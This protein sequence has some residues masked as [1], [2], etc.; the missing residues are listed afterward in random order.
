MQNVLNEID[1]LGT[2]HKW[3]IAY[4]LF[5]K[6]EIVNKTIMR[7]S[8]NMLGI[9]I[10]ACHLLVFRTKNYPLVV[11]GPYC[12]CEDTDPEKNIFSKC[13]STKNKFVHKKVLKIYVF[14]IGLE[15]VEQHKMYC[16]W[17]SG[18][19]LLGNPKIYVL[20]KI[21]ISPFFYD[22]G[23]AKQI[24]TS[25]TSSNLLMNFHSCTSILM[26]STK[27]NYALNK[28]VDY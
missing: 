2:N 16:L 21:I 13:P 11:F 15:M 4:F 19:M 27:Y 12:S 24:T 26:H 20:W 22:S 10:F 23:K 5:F 6:R 1:L 28:W 7:K 18:T 3:E 17:N 14:Q 9:L 25:F 8:W